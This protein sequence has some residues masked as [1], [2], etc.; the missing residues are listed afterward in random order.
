MIFAG[1]FLM[2]GVALAQSSVKGTVTS[3]EDGE[4]IVG[5]SVMV[6]GTKTGT[7][8]DLDGHFELNVPAGSKLVITYL[9]MKKKTV[10][11]AANM[12]VALDSDNKELKEVVVTAMGIT[13]DKKALGYSSQNLKASDLNVAGTSSLASALQGKLTG[14]SIRQ[15]SGAP[16]ASAQITIR[17]ARSFDG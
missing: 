13:R 9:G 16:G 6:D 8:T 4:P 10:T 17:G 1:L 15:S 14:V 5:A 7:V 12:K 2:I 3:S 11:A